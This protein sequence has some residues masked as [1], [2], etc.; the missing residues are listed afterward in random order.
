[1]LT[2][3]L[4]REFA[5]TLAGAVIISGFVAVTITPMMSARILKPGHSRFQGFIDRTFDRI[6]DRYERLVSGSLKYRPVTLMVVVALMS[7]TGY[8]FIKSSSELAPEE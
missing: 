8:M 1:G 5:V 3:S 4:F 2:G 6:A 7:I